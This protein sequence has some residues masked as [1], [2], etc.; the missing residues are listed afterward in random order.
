MTIFDSV[1]QP[2][3]PSMSPVD[4]A[5]VR[6]GV[7]VGVE[8]ALGVVTVVDAVGAGVSTASKDDVHPESATLPRATNDATWITRRQFNMHGL[9]RVPT[10]ALLSST[11]QRFRDAHA[12]TSFL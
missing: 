5:G 6:A 8:E 12:S 9:Y 1:E 11:T 7:G 4:G 2:A 10:S 3:T